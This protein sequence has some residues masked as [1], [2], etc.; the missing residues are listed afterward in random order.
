MITG[1]SRGKDLSYISVSL[2]FPLGV[3][4][5]TL[6][7]EG[8]WRELGCLARSA[9]FA[10]RE[11]S[12]HSLKSALSVCHWIITVPFK[13]CFIIMSWLWEL[14]I[15]DDCTSSAD[16]L[17]VL[18]AAH[19]V[20]WFKEL[21]H[22]SQQRCLTSHQ[23]GKCAHRSTLVHIC[24]PHFWLLTLDLKSSNPHICQ[25]VFDLIWPLWQIRVLR[26][27]DRP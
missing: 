7:W 15:I 3:T 21:C 12:G 5:H 27:T 4:N 17:L 9:S 18:F 16:L 20:S 25:Y 6:K 22:L 10:V 24:L 1:I 13:M 11:E 23:P 2:Q 14:L 26:Q 19:C 8:V